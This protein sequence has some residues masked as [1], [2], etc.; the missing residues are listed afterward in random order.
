MIFSFFVAILLYAFGNWI[1]EK[2]YSTFGFAKKEVLSWSFGIIALLIL[3][4]KGVEIFSHF[5]GGYIYEMIAFRQ[6]AM[7]NLFFLPY[8]FSAIILFFLISG[9]IENIRNNSTFFKT[10]L[11]AVFGYLV[12]VIF[13]GPLRISSLNL[14][15]VVPGWHNNIYPPNTFYIALNIVYNS[16]GFIISIGFL[17]LIYSKIIHH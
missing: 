10:S 5:Y 7:G 3:S 13:F 2:Y 17:N 9:L 4:I 14:G 1:L 15:S 8:L 6:R 11:I 16:S 12:F